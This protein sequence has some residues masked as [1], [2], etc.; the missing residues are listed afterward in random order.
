MPANS[1]T[2]T[3]SHYAIEPA[4]DDGI[5]DGSHRRTQQNSKSQ[6]VTTVG[7]ILTSEK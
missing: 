5:D 6:T 7:P 1:N 2:D 4:E 3:S